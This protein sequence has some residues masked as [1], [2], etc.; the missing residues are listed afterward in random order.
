MSYPATPRPTHSPWGD[1][2]NATELAPG[3]WQ[4]STASHGGILLSPERWQDMTVK[5]TP[6]SHDGW[7][8]E[9]CDWAY[10]AVRFPE[11]FSP[12]ALEAAKRTI[13]TLYLENR[14]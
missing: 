2:Q 8:E 14:Q 1:V 12:E 10:V 9:D 13:A 4:S 7:Y 3:I 6:Y 5:G 11:A